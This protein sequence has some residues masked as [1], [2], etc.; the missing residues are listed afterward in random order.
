[1]V[2]LLGAHLYTPLALKSPEGQSGKDQVENPG[3]DQDQ[4]QDQVG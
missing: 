4:G 2:A 1:L 3:Q